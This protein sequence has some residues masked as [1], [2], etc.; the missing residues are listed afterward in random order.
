MLQQTHSGFGK[1]DVRQIYAGSRFF[2]FV[3]QSYWGYAQSPQNRYIGIGAVR[4][5]DRAPP[6]PPG[7]RVRTG[8][9]EKL[10]S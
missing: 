2:I 4:I 1:Q 9:F 3:K 5:S 10:R 7:M 8:R 6:T